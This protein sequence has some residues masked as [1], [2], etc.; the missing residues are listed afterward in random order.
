MYAADQH[1]GKS[2]PSLQIVGYLGFFI[3]SVKA[4]EVAGY[5]TPITGIYK[6]GGPAVNGGFAK[7]IMLVQ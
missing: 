3:D 7:V 2:Q 4:G 1:S 5:I 6:K